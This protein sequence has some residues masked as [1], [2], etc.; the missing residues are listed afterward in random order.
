MS[1]KQE[2]AKMSYLTPSMA[3]AYQES[4]LQE[5]KKGRPVKGP[6]PPRPGLVGRLLLRLGNIFIS[7]GTKLRARYEPAICP[8]PEIY[9]SAAGKARA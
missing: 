9:P 3:R 6:L 8:C 5:T 4:L 1:V 2:E 7:L